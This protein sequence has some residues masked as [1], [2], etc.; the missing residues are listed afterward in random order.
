MSPLKSR[1][2]PA[3]GRRGGVVMM[4]P[5]SSERSE[6]GD[7]R[8]EMGDALRRADRALEGGDGGE[9]RDERREEVRERSG[10]VGVA[11]A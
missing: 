3:A 4:C 5:S 11:V 6:M 8:S 7:D 1:S 9:R 2:V 10:D